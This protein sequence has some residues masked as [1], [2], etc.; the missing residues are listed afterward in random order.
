MAGI[1]TIFLDSLRE[2]P[3]WDLYI[4]SLAELLGESDVNMQLTHNNM[5]QTLPLQEEYIVSMDGWSGQ[6]PVPEGAVLKICYDTVATLVKSEGCQI[7]WDG[8]VYKDFDQVTET[9]YIRTKKQFPSLSDIKIQPYSWY[10][11]TFNFSSLYRSL[12]VWA[13]SSG[14]EDSSF[15][16]DKS[17]TSPW[18]LI[19][20]S[21][22]LKIPISLRY[23]FRENVD[24]P[25]YTGSSEVLRTKMCQ[26]TRVGTAIYLASVNNLVPNYD[27]ISV[28]DGLIQVTAVSKNLV[29]LKEDIYSGS[30][31]VYR[32][33]YPVP[34]S[35]KPLTSYIQ[36]IYDKEYDELLNSVVQRLVPFRCKSGHLGYWDL[37]LKGTVVTKSSSKIPE[38]A[39]Q[40][41][42]LVSA[43][44]HFYENLLLRVG[45]IQVFDGE[46]RVTE[47][48]ATE[49]QFEEFNL[50]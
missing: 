40:G 3:A 7:S 9:F 39:I 22:N 4:K 24:A 11:N 33:H 12:D 32:T 41:K 48:V 21:N 27:Y 36:I 38:T 6:G 42:V 13:Y 43:L 50:I 25:D 44:V 8:I 2:S 30:Y 18:N 26:L 10:P 16:M 5:P 17:R 28:G 35:R 45:E 20:I 1:E 29:Y 47:V 14:I 31:D 23:L 19:R 49:K 15:F 46:K 37:E 34:T